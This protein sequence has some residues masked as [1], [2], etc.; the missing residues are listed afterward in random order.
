ME[1]GHADFAVITLALSGH[2]GIPH[3]QPCL[4]GL[5]HSQVGR[6]RPGLYAGES[7]IARAWPWPCPHLFLLHDLITL[8]TPGSAHRM[9][10]FVAEP[11]TNGRSVL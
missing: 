2:I 4:G 10:D 9:T 11:I 3:D 6:F 8:Y 1:R 7:Y 5:N